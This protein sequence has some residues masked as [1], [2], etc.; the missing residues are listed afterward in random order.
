MTAVDIAPTFIRHARD[1]EREEPRGIRYLVA[2]GVELPFPD[3]AF[4]FVTGFM[5]F[6]DIPETGRLL[7]PRP[8]A[9]SAQ[10]A[11]S[12]SPSSTPASPSSEA[13]GSRTRTANVSA[14]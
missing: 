5:S 7:S 10:V 2:S 4:D 14:G 9:S 12:S 11:S 13:T 6:M 3:R 8:T 1:A